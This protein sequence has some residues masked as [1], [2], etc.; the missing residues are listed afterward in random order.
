M[1]PPLERA[2]R[3]LCKLHGHPPDI[4]MDGRPMWESYIPEVTAVV[5]ALGDGG[6]RDP[7]AEGRG[8]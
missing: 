2:C 8:R 5:E 6:P 1:K 7:Q 4:K 3:A